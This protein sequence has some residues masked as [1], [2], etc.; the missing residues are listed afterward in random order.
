M[1][2]SWWNLILGGLS[3]FGFGV[4]WGL[5]A[6]SELSFCLLLDAP[7]RWRCG[8]LEACDHVLSFLQ[9]ARFGVV[10]ASEEDVCVCSHIHLHGVYVSGH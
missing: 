7:F 4:V 8:F 1:V 9:M 5:W 10:E 3:S 6:V 2:Q